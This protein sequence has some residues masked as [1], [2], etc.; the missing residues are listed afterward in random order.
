MKKKLNW[1]ELKERVTNALKFIS[2]TVIM[3]MGFWLIYAII[4]MGI[5]LPTTNWAIWI[6]FMLALVSEYGYIKW[7]SN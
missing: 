6:L 5:R 3:V 4:W 2:L 1:S 7:L